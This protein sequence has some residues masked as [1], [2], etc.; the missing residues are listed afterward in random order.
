[1]KACANLGASIYSKTEGRS[2]DG[3]HSG[4]DLRDYRAVLRT[5]C[6]EI[7]QGAIFGSRFCFD[8]KR[9]APHFFILPQLPPETR[10]IGAR[11]LMSLA[12]P[13]VPLNRTPAAA[14]YK[15]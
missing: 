9:Q 3:R 4:N 5:L 11:W 14:R 15:S 7:A 1:M 6:I 8:L 13:D 10:R 12:M 2:F